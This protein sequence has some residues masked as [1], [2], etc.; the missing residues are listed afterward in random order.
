LMNEFKQESHKRASQVGECIY[1][2]IAQLRF[3]H[4]HLPCRVPFINTLSSFVVSQ[5]PG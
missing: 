4:T 2:Y 3:Y 1:G 5:F